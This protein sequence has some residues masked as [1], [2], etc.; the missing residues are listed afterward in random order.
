[1]Y[2]MMEIINSPGWV[3]LVSHLMIVWGVLALSIWILT[4]IGNNL[5]ESAPPAVRGAPWTPPGE[6]IGAVWSVLYSLMAI[7]L[8]LL[9]RSELHNM[10]SLKLI[11]ILLIGFCIL[12]PF[13]AFSE[14]SRL[15]GL[16]G[17]VGIFVIAVV[18][19]WRLM[20]YSQAAA[21]MIVPTAVWI[22]VA[23]ASILDGARRYGW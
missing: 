22:T 14:S 9:N 11:I 3:G 12:W 7:A 8:W 1:M 17:N 10:T 18:A 2:R 20:P 19:I 15:P 4:A 5:G 6:I 13:Y 21:I 23:I 16:V